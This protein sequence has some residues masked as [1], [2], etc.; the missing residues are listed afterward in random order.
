MKHPFK[1]G[2]LP[3]D[4]W[5]DKKGEWAF[6]TYFLAKKSFECV[7]FRFFNSEEKRIALA[8]CTNQTADGLLGGPQ[9]APT[10]LEF[11][12]SP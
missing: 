12:S 1:K 10:F 7:Q 2:V 6:A 11:V 4:E 9:R 3:K 8:V 5:K